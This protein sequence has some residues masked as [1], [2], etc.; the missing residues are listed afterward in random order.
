LIVDNASSHP[1][2]MAPLITLVKADAAFVTCLVPVGKGEF[3]AVKT[4]S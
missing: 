4:S 3:L 1:Q 2:E